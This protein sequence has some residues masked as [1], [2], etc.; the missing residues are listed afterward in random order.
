MSGSLRKNFGQACHI[1]SRLNSFDN[2]EIRAFLRLNPF[3]LVESKDDNNNN[4]NNISKNNNNN[5]NNNNN[6]KT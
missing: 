6:S 4:N 5:N 3:G 2:F 1:Q